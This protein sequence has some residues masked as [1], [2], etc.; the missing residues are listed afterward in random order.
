MTKNTPFGIRMFNGLTLGK[1]VTNPNSRLAKMV[2]YIRENGP[3]TR[4]DLG[5]G[6]LG[7]RFSVWARN[8]NSYAFSGAVQA[9]FLTRYR[10]GQK[11]YYNL[12]TRSGLVV[13]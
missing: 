3:S 12:G 4:E 9:G 11:V 1:S 8:W 2:N 6:A 13:K 7:F 5:R 10:V